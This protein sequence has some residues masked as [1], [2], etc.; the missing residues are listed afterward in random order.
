MSQGWT[1]EYAPAAVRFLERLRDAKLL[2]R[3]QKTLE[4]LQSEP[5]PSGSIKLSGEDDLHRIR[6][7]D[8]R[9]LYALRETQLLVLVVDIGHRREIYR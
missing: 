9:I 1:L 7:G 4:G 5:H 8:Y 3:L 6:V 2:K